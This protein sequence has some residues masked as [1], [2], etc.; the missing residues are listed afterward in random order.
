MKSNFVTL[1]GKSSNETLL[2]TGIGRWFR[3][4]PNGKSS[5]ATAFSAKSYLPV[6]EIVRSLS[7][8]AAQPAN[9]RAACPG[10]AR[11]VR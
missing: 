2:R 8:G 1:I 4:H 7:N 10:R 3:R 9:W 6:A 5:G 11:L